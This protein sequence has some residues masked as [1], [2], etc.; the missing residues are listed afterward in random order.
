MGAHEKE[1]P[2]VRGESGR[3]RLYTC[4]LCPSVWNPKNCQK[5]LHGIVRL[6]MNL[7]IGVRSAAAEARR[8]LVANILNA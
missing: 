2:G 8:T 6:P 7:I 5:V 3:L 4:Q 1:M